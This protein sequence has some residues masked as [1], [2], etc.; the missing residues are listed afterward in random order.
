MWQ[1]ALPLLL[2]SLAGCAER[3]GVVVKINVDAADLGGEK[4]Q[5]FRLILGSSGGDSGSALFEAD[6]PIDSFPVT[7]S[8][9]IDAKRADTD[10][11]VAVVGVTDRGRALLSGFREVTIPN[12]E[13]F[14]VVID[15]DQED[16]CTGGDG[17]DLGCC[18]DLLDNDGNGLIDCADQACVDAFPDLCTDNECGDGITNPFAG[19][20]CDPNDPETQT[21]CDLFCLNGLDT[22]NLLLR[23]DETGVDENDPDDR[24]SG[25]L[26]HPRI[27]PVGFRTVRAVND[28]ETSCEFAIRHFGR[29]NQDLDNFPFFFAFGGQLQLERADG[30]VVQSVVPDPEQIDDFYGGVPSFA[31]GEPF[32]ARTVPVGGDDILVEKEL[33]VGAAPSHFDFADLS[34][35]G[36][37]NNFVPGNFVDIVRGEEFVVEWEPI[38]SGEEVF[39]SIQTFAQETFTLCRAPESAGRLVVP[40]SLTAVYPRRL[41]FFDPDVNATIINYFGTFGH[42]ISSQVGVEV[43][44]FLPDFGGIQVPGQV[45]FQFID[46]FSAAGG[47]R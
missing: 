34:S 3:I 20:L 31:D 32:R 33:L 14:E 43:D 6:E 27:E 25:V 45:T 40:A 44:E 28:G 24:R 26:Y 13:E 37:D 35:F 38:N 19:E 12:Q 41:S 15:L 36:D 47:V 18:T 10:L 11:R 17:A 7:L 5:S 2:L 9:R 21:G 30:T 42:G 4:L 1:R 29:R 23:Y 16:P 46:G 22:T 8:T 39:F